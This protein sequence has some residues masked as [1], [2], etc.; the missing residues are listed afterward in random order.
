MHAQIL[1]AYQLKSMD[2]VAEV[3]LHAM[4]LVRKPSSTPHHHRDDDDDDSQ[5]ATS[6]AERISSAMRSV[7]GRKEP[8]SGS[9]IHVEFPDLHALPG[10][11]FDN[12]PFR[13][14]YDR[15]VACTG[16]QFDD[17]MFDDSVKPELQTSRHGVPKYPAVTPAY[18]STNVPGLHFVGTTMHGRDY[19]HTAG[20]FIHG[21]R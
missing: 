7:M 9:A 14:P 4:R 8:E 5:H 18:E 21:F 11:G 6:P 10:R 20:G 12:F 2:A 16:W 17:S 13:Q 3:P 19:K 1:E 15:V